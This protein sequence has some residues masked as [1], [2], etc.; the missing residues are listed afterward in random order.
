LDR[1]A[2]VLFSGEYECRWSSEHFL[3]LRTFYLAI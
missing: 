1:H 3:S 2:V